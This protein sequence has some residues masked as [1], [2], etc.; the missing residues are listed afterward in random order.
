MYTTD[1]KIKLKLRI[2][3]YRILLLTDG[4]FTTLLKIFNQG[5]ATI[6]RKLY[7]AVD[8]KGW[9]KDL[10]LSQGLVKENIVN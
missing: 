1:G 4:L 8:T 6:R 10:C 2:F 9:I 3:Q 7:R 5:H